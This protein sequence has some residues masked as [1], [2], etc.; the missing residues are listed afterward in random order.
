MKV[1]IFS[2]THLGFEERSERSQESFDNLESAISLSLAGNADVIVIAGDVFDAPVPSHSVLYKSMQ[3]FSIS[4]RKDSAVSLKLEKGGISRDIAVSGTPVIAIHGNHEFFGKE[5]KTALDVLDLSGLVIYLHAG[6]I[7]AQK[8]SEKL[9]IYGLGAVPEKR[10]LDVM[11]KWGPVPE[12][13]SPNILLV[14]QAFKEFMAVDDEMVAT[15]SLDDLP[16]G[17]DLTVDGHLH[18]RNEQNLGDSIFLLAGSTI[19]TSIKKLEAQKPKGVYFFDTTS[20][21]LS[22]VPFDVQRKAFYHK[23]TFKDSGPQDVI[24]KCRELILQDLKEENRL[25]PLI[26]LNLKGT[27]AKGINSADV[28]LKPVLDE[29]AQSALLSVSKNFSDVSFKARIEEL[30]ELQKSRLSIAAMGFEL[31]ERSLSEAEFDGTFPSRGLFD[32]LAEDEI[33]NAFKLLGVE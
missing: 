19:A 25:K 7:E 12:K 31:L 13:G 26:R 32:S 6:R 10:A 27:L 16:K 20:K 3:S 23:M 22:F 8:G 5:A 29:F 11:A 9:Y 15:L 21:A 28:N 14:H 2:D 18:W 17:F 1:A 4:K 33:E 30:A 24:A